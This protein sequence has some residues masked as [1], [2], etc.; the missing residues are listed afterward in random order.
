MST[1][2]FFLYKKRNAGSFHVSSVADPRHFGAAPDADPG[3]PEPY[4]SY[5]SGSGYG[6]GTLVQLHHSSK[7]KTS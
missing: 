5:G 1:D 7:I 4:E 3:G 6:S 2:I